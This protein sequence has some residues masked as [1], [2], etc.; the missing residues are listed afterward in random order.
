MD[1]EP[2]L[3]FLMLTLLV[4]IGLFLYPWKAVSGRI[5]KGP[6]YALGLLIAA[7]A[8][9]GSFFLPYGPRC[10]YAIAFLAGWLFPPSGSFPGAC[11]RRDRG[12]SGRDRER[13]EG[14]Y[15]GS[16]LF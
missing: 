8:V 3:S 13:R 5:N 7:L 16:G 15:Y 10:A 1:M 6:C 12:R 11:C 14:I 9:I 2:Q 4:A